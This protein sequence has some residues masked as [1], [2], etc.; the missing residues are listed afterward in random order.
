MTL[1][2]YRLLGPLEIVSDGVA[3]EPGSGKQ[4][5][6]LA[7]FLVNPGQTFSLDRIVDALWDEPPASAAKIVQNCVVRL[8]RILP[9]GALVTHRHGYELQLGEGDHTDIEQFAALVEQANAAV[10]ADDHREALRVLTEA[11]A[12]WRGPALADVRSSPELRFEAERLDELRLFALG[13][14]IDAELALGGHEE[15]IGELA[16]LVASNPLRERLRAQLMLAYYRSGRQDDAL[17]VYRSARAE[18]DAQLGVEPGPALKQLEQ[19]ILR[20][21]PALDAPL[22]EHEPRA[23][24]RRHQL[25]RSRLVMALVLIVLLAIAAAIGVLVMHGGS[26]VSFAG[27]RVLVIEGEHPRVVSSVQTGPAPV[28]IAFS[29]DQAFILD[30]GRGTLATVDVAK[31]TSASD[32]FAVT[33]TDMNL[34]LTSVA[35]DSDGVV[36][37]IDSANGA[38]TEVSDVS[39]ETIVPLIHAAPYGDYMTL[40]SGLG[41][42][43]ATSATKHAVLAFDFTRQR[44]MWQ[45]HVDGQPDGVTTGAGAVWCISGK[46]G[47]RGVVTRIDPRTHRLVTQF[48][49]AG[50][51]TDIVYGL[52]SIWVAV[53]EESTIYRIDPT[54][55]AVTR[56]Y[57]ISQLP[58]SLAIL[59][60]RLW[61][62]TAGNN[63]V[64][65]VDPG[66][67]RITATVD[68]GAAPYRLA[69]YAGRVWV[70]T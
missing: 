10:N 69:A 16:R 21:D 58:R 18:L 48:H 20:Q 55:N 66:T 60:N 11:L 30:E 13:G 24:H 45:T 34:A 64:S 28:G 9:A 49:L 59:G 53:P 39:D 15:L 42:L 25:R 33:T 57:E 2:A 31:P 40:A 70:V 14:R 17:N 32:V 3:I 12:L 38:L 41:K 5:E 61:V 22:R 35:S 29:G 52:G 37:V 47:R 50:V 44:L 36:W 56:T 68:V 65:V 63:S 26:K 46:A 67:G 54:R 62:G 4:R 6:L 8:R 27:K 23:F 43:W 51:P 1:V 19:S 7:L